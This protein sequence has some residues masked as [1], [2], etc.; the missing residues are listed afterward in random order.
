MQKEN[1]TSQ[2]WS[3]EGMEWGVGFSWG[4]VYAKSSFFFPLTWRRPVLMRSHNLPRSQQLPGFVSLF[5]FAFLFWWEELCLPGQASAD[6]TGE[7][8]NGWFT[9]CLLSFL[10]TLWKCHVSQFMFILFTEQ[11][12]RINNNNTLWG[13]CQL[14]LPTSVNWN[15]YNSYNFCKNFNM[16]LLLLHAISRA[17]RLG[18]NSGW[19]LCVCACACVCVNVERTEP[20]TWGLPQLSLKGGGHTVEKKL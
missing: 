10:P 7:T 8:S 2:D 19:F 1:N 9:S 4:L 20:R 11:T 6:V 15:V 13:T 5:S 14:S 3:A 17:V 12:R 16:Q 18:C